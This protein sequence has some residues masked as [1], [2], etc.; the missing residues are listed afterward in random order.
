ME[1]I[2]KRYGGNKESKKVQRTL[3]KQ[4][5]E[6][7][8]ASSSETLDQ[9]FDRFQ[10]LISQLE[11]QG[12]SSTSQNPQ[13][14]AFVS[15]NNT[16][17]TSSTNET[18]NTTYEVSTAHTQGLQSVKERLAHYKK[19][20]ENVKS[21]SDKG[22]HEVSPPYTGNYIPPKHD[23]T[24]I[25]EQVKS[26]YVD[27]VSNVASSDVKTVESK[28]ESVDVKNKGVYSTIETKP[29]RKNNFSPPVIED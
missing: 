1:G 16:N 10:K 6:N 5:Y 17:I 29:V 7:F 22:Y 27:V 11:I 2:E 18:D 20:E 12:S 26:N 21:I 24:F 8:A 25:D 3:F 19:K 13:N 4:K 14:I 28:H 15:S 9:T 23:L